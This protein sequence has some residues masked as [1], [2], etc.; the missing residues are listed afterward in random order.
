MVVKPARIVV[1]VLPFFTLRRDKMHAIFRT[2]FSNAFSLIKLCK[3]RWRFHWTMLMGPINNIPALVQILVWQRPGDK[4]FSEP[5]MVALLTHICVTRLQWVKMH[6][7]IEKYCAPKVE[8]LTH[9]WVL[10]WCYSMV[11]TIH[12]DY[13]YA[14]RDSTPR[15]WD[16]RKHHSRDSCVIAH[17]YYIRLLHEYD[18]QCKLTW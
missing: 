7:L 15:S 14:C 17:D 6:H 9:I 3:F 5:L 1:M 8:T 18:G 4:P 2:T 13:S 16:Y 10:Y 12:M 11:L